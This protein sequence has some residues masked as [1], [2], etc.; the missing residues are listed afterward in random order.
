MTLISEISHTRAVAY[1]MLC[2]SQHSLPVWV[3]R[4]CKNNHDLK[5]ALGRYGFV[6]SPNTHIVLGAKCMV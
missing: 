5:G 6:D 2:R 4:V 3:R 1:C